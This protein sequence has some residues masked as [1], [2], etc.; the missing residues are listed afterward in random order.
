MFRLTVQ[1]S[2]VVEEGGQ[3][4]QYFI[5]ST[6]HT[7]IRTVYSKQSYRDKCI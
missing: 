4:G 2:A 7:V 1:P 6:V 5:P 3:E